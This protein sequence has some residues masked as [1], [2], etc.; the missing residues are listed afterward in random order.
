MDQAAAD[1]MREEWAPSDKADALWAG[2]P[3]A[4]R[5]LQDNAERIHA[6]R[7]E[8][9]F[10]QGDPGDCMYLVLSGRLSVRLVADDGVET[11]LAELGPGM[12][13]GEIALLTGQPRT[14]SV[15]AAEDA[16]LLRCS[17]VSYERLARQHP[18]ELAGF[19][20]TVARRLKEVHLSQV[21]GT[22]FGIQDAQTLGWLRGELEWLHLGHSEVL[23]RQDEPSDAMYIVVSGRLRIST[24]EANGTARYVGEVSPGEVVGELGLLSGEPRTAT[25]RAI[26]QT[27]VVKVSQ[28]VFQQLAELYPEAVMRIAKLI[29][30]RHQRSMHAPSSAQLRAL[31]LAIIPTMTA[32]SAAQFAEE[33]ASHLEMHGTVLTVDSARLDSHLGKTGAA[34]AEPN[35]PTGLIVSTWLGE[36]ESRFQY[37]LLVADPEWS[38]WT[39]RC[40]CQA[41]RVLQ[42]VDAHATP[43]VGPI[44]QAMGKRELLV[45]HELIL[46]H[47][48]NTVEPANTARWLAKRNV[49][50]HH[51]VRAGDTA[52]M[53]RLAN[54][55]TGKAL[56]MVLSGGGARGMA[57][58]G[59][60]RAME[61]LGIGI[62]LIGGTSMGSLVGAVY[63]MD[64]EIDEC[65][66][67]A[68]RFASPR[69][70]FDYT[71]P[72]ASLMASKKV[73]R[74]LRE[75]LGEVCIEDLW[76]PFFCVSS[77]LTRAEAVIHRTGP[78]WEAVR[79]SIAIPGIFTPIL[80]GRDVLVDGGALNNFPV[81]IM[82]TLC[83]GGPV[84]G[85][86]V[87]PMVDR[88][89]SYEFGSSINGWRVLWSRLNPFSP[90]MRVPSLLGS[91]MRAQEIRGISGLRHS[92]TIADMTVRPDVSRYSILDFAAYEPIIEIGYRAAL[93]QLVPWLEQNGGQGQGDL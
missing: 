69:K 16:Q 36:Q 31:V 49:H 55:L 13:V 57:H 58:V 77:N 17:R 78:L 76:R 45:R 56:G 24:A 92:E 28:P 43:D 44:E 10:C 2:D 85:S 86:S 68:E 63:A 93:D 80:Q 62:D 29:I 83:E 82:E 22:F 7:G 90:T 89:D 74:V 70:L 23:F 12:P 41:D 48:K 5:L 40:V 60:L 84:V 21:L 1:A 64:R 66:T 52:H 61:E 73:T 30:S 33:L 6:S 72:V 81:D 18:K 32:L 8:L 9:L 51:H 39:E 25:A 42:L 19:T 79:A 54:R 87:C 46:V 67:L 71:L 37:L 91:L 26:R 53:R 15:Y 38:V 3:F 11:Q 35:H 27:D 4:R 59:V 65:M 47:P 50:A 20:Q 75:M 14:A 88:Y 34:N